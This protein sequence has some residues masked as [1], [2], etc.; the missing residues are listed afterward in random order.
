MLALN[1]GRPELLT[2]R[3]IIAA[4]IAFR[5]EVITRRTMHLLGKARERAH[6]LVGL[7]IAVESIDPI[8]A[9]IRAS[10]DPAAARAGLVGQRWPPAR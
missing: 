6:I 2:L 7:L 3:D 9:L 5:E 8:I 1:G 10:A 4:F